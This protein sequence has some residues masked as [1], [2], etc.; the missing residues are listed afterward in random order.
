MDRRA[1]DQAVARIIELLSDPGALDGADSSGRL[2]EGLLSSLRDAGLLTLMV[3]PTLGGLGLSWTNAFRVVEA[4]AG[5]SMAVAFTIAIN[6]GFG[7]GSYLP[8]LPPGPLRDLIAERV[9]DGIF[10]GGADAEPAGTANRRRTTVAVPVDGGEAYLI[11]GEKVF[12]GN[13]PIADLLDVSA[14]LVA[15]DGTETVRLFFVDTRSPGF[16]VV[17]THEFMGLRGAAI[18][19]LRLNGVRVPAERLMPEQPDDGWRMR[20]DRSTPPGSPPAQADLGR[21]ALL[22]RHLVIAPASLAVARMSLLWSK[23]FANRRSID[24]RGLGEYEETQRLVAETA[25]E[26]FAIETVSLWCLL[27]GDRADTRPDVSAA[28][29]L[30]S[31]ASWRAIDRTL[32]LLGAEGYETARSKAARGAPPLPVERFF[33]DARSLR[34]AGGV[35]FMLDKWCAEAGLSPYY[36]PGDGL[37][38][39][40][41][42]TPSAPAVPGGEHGRFIAAQAAALAERC[43]SLTARLPR[44][45]LF[46]RQRAVGL[47][48]RIATELLGM[49]LTV[50]RSADLAERGDTT[51][52]DLADIACD[53]STYRLRTLWAQLDRETALDGH[54]RHRRTGQAL[55][56]GTASLVFPLGEGPATGT[57]APPDGD[58]PQGDPPQGDPESAVAAVWRELFDL[59]RIGRHDDFFELGGHSLLAIR[60]ASRLRETMGLRVPVRVI[61][62]NP[63]IAEIA[64][65]I[66]EVS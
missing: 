19:M 49:S 53:A 13:G 47:I 20:P 28:K 48:G 6:N 43:R 35:D 11:T 7:S 27:G 58:P 33:R 50:A 26:V 12:I 42:D 5:R 4:A 3:D 63:T 29:N 55:L 36:R 62:D 31:L 8:A 23:D 39:P 24:G 57:H 44:D 59:D 51:A 37:S 9:A 52:L 25:A 22:G 18:G 15:D 64:R 41:S 2:P 56:D 1:G 60:M 21:L 30:T 16:E 66:E 65:R 14:T 46:A 17:T 38:R 45:E 10:S 61:Y 34:V 40:A 54:I 32:S